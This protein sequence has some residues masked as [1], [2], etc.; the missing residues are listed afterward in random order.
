MAQVAQWLDLPSPDDAGTTRVTGLSLG[1]QRVLPGDL[2]A[3]LPGARVHGAT[4]ARDAV[5][6]GAVAILTDP[7]GAA[8]L[9]DPAGGPGNPGV[10]VLV[11]DDPRDRLG[12]LAARVHDNPATNLAMIGVTG[13]QGKTT[14]TRL[15]E[16]ALQA[17]SVPAAVVGT[18][19]TRINGVDIPTTLTTPEAPDLHALFAL[20]VE[21][22]VH[23]CAMEVS[24]HALVMGRVD[25]IVFDVAVFTNLGRDHL[26]F[27]TDVEDYFAAKA[28]LFTPQR[29]RRGLVNLDDDHGRRLR[30]EAKI[31]IRT[32]ALNDASAD[33]R[34]VDLDLQPQRSEFTVLGPDG[35][36]V[37]TSVPIAG[38]FNV[39]NALAAIAAAAE[40]GH[41]PEQVA[42]GMARGG[43]V[44]GR[45]ERVEVPG[46]ITAVV[47][48]AHKPDAVEAAL[49]TLRPLT[50]GRLIIVIGAG[51]DRDSGKRP[52]MGEI[53]ARLADLVVVTDDNPRTE[54]PAAIRSQVL[55]G[56]A[57][58]GEVIEVAGR[59]AAIRSAL[60][61]AVAGDIVL[62]AGKGHETGQEIN[63]VVH[64]FDDR[65]VVAEEA[66]R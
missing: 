29:A 53:A 20:M 9:R 45:L 23:T 40:A 41:D 1:S 47:D 38:D 31:P 12:A 46:G 27:H 64:P 62:V 13:T 35:I 63:G 24:S 59:R 14:T 48:Y 58:P 4:Y 21:Q 54:D 10:P 56:A 66:G 18:V 44:P 8:L 33:W 19:G 11:V 51:G 37:R 57:G 39:A 16:I 43:G 52:V 26:D 5:A 65:V 30:D 50:S 7:A 6:A 25:G 28:R 60:E 22:G 15:L 32:F 34:A 55:A 2:Y 3:A 17:A 49:T 36:R 42:Q 61:Q